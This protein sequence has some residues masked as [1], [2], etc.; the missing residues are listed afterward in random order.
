M[1]VAYMWRVIWGPVPVTPVIMSLGQLRSME[2]MGA[3]CSNQERP[4]S[5]V[6]RYTHRDVFG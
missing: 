3:Q 1:P 4:H 6:K 2:A 5:C